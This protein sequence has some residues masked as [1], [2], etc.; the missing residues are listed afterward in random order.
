MKLTTVFFDFGG[1]L[2]EPIADALDVWLALSKE[3]RLG[4]DRETLGKALDTANEWFRAVVYEY[5][6][7][8]AELW[9]TYDRVVLRELGIGNPDDR[10]VATIE[11]RFKDTLSQRLYPETRAV[12]EKLRTRG[13]TLGVISNATEEVVDR[14]R[15]LD[16]AKY[17]AHITYSQEA[18]TDKPEPP[19]FLLALGRARCKPEEAVHLGNMYEH[20]VIGAR[21]VGIR[22]ILVDRDGSRPD[23]D[24]DRVTDLCGVLPLLNV[25]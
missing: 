7:R 15:D 11:E 1:T 23:A 8:T 20:D 4:A 21:R 14:L 6:G 9:P 17:F 18:G 13:F 10:L 24:C 12:L 2:A 16:I 3:L 19:I 25:L 5:H 22:P